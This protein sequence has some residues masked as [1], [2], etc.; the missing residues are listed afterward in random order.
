[1]LFSMNYTWS[2][3]IDDGSMGSGDGDSLTPQN[4]ACRSC[5]RASGV[6]DARHVVNANVLYELPLG[7]GKLYLNQP[8]F[9]RTTFGSWELSTIVAAHTG[10]PVNATVDRAASSVP[11]GNTNNQ[12][13]DLISGMSVL[14]PGSPCVLI[15]LGAL[16]PPAPGTFGDA[17]RGLLRG[18][19]LWQ[20]DVG[21]AK[22]IPLSE[23]VQLQFRAEAFNVFNRAQWGPPQADT[24]NLLTFGKVISTVNPGPVGTGT[25]RQLQFVLKAQF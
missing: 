9:L 21:L 4:V 7:P 12:R 16:C 8:G 22:H 20:A 14:P 19:G 3:E 10:F 15:N 25:P 6:W 23:R 24:S 13:P 11:D 5:E 1:L 17:P 18:P 2:H